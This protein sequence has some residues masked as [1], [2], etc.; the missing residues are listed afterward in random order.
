MT[1]TGELHAID[2]LQVVVVVDGGLVEVVGSSGAQKL[3]QSASF[4]C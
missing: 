4:G 1:Q 3:V 2:G